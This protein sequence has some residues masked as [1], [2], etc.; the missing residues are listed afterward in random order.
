MRAATAVAS[1]SLD[2][3]G[4]ASPT[5]R[6]GHQRGVGDLPSAVFW[7]KGKGKKRDRRSV[8]RR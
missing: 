6:P 2:A 8:D 5:R 4:T 7:G 1:G 3:E